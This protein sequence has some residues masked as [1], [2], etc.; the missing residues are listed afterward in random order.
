MERRRCSERLRG[1]DGAAAQRRR[2][3]DGSAFC[4]GGEKGPRALILRCVWAS[5][6]CCLPLP[7]VY[8]CLLG[9]WMVDGGGRTPGAH[10]CASL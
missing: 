9:W 10:K 2:H 6:V 7:S 1:K 5:G 4:L 3:A 8:V